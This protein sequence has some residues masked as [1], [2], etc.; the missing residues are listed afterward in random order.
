MPAAVLALGLTALP[1]AARDGLD[2][3]D[4]RVAAAPTDLDAYY[5][6]HLV[7][8]RET[9]YR[10]AERRL[11][12]L[13][14]RDP[15]NDW[16]RLVLASIRGDQNGADA[17]EL[18]TAAADGFAARG[19]GKGEILA[20]IFLA[21]YHQLRGRAPLAD[22]PLSRA[23]ELADAA[24]DPI[25]S[26][27]VR[28]AEAWQSYRKGDHGRALRLLDGVQD[29]VFGQGP[30]QLQST[31]L[32]ASAI[33][34]WALG[35]HTEAME[36]YR[37][38]AELLR[39]QGDRYEEAVAR[40]NIIF[41]APILGMSREERLPLAQELLA[42]AIAGGNRSMEARAH[43]YLAGLTSGREAITHGR[44]YLLMSRQTKRAS[45]IVMALRSLAPLLAEEDPQEARRLVDEAAA[46]ARESGDL[47]EVARVQVARSTVSWMTGLRSQA[48]AESLAALDAIEAT[49]GR[50]PE[51][52]VRARRFSQ[53]RSVYTRLTGSL[54]SGRLLAAGDV[55][56]AEDV[57]LA[58]HV[59]ERRRAR[60]LLDEMDAARATGAPGLVALSP[61]R[62]ATLAE[63][64]SALEDDEALLSFQIAEHGAS[65]SPIGEGAGGCWLIVQTRHRTRLYPL[66][67]EA[68][69]A[70][71]LFVGLFERRDGS[72]AVPASRL[73]AHLLE[74]ALGDLP[75]IRRLVVVPDDVLHRVPFDAL[76]VG[77]VEPLGAR[78][79]IS[80]VPSATLWLRL[81]RLRATL[82][83]APA[84]ALSDPDLGVASESATERQW[85]LDVGA[86]LGRLPHARREGGMIVRRL[87][88]GSRVLS[89]L[90]AS[91]EYLKQADLSRYALL[92]FAAHAVVDESKPERSA[93]LLAPGS[94]TEDGLLQVRELVGLDLG[95]RVVVLSTCRSASGALI[96]GEGLLSLAHGFFQAGARTVVGTLWPL[97]DDEAER[98]FDAF[99]G[100]LAQGLSVG[101]ALAGARRERIDA[102]APAAAWAGMVLLGDATAVPVPGGRPSGGSRGW[103]AA[104]IAV[105]GAVVGALLVRSRSRRAPGP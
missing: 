47:E 18:Y 72:E 33:V 37:R 21:T 99:Y 94:A 70:V 40:G 59:T 11:R 16:A 104:S 32:S 26:A 9:R 97:R 86:R 102:G 38:Q 100:R 12:A 63:L 49:R 46:L 42:A 29:V 1:A 3:C 17:E 27:R 67:A 88:G 20:R 79:D 34:C 78:Y 103:A 84:L 95:R 10:E 105:V 13:L 51:A 65:S 57:E 24:A 64:K 2:A 4:A 98:L 14:H 58:F 69:T 96:G 19:D 66:P 5:C 43:D 39:D 87:G 73:G 7:A 89:G 48:I 82:A 76:R 15:R 45:A 91:E 31:W 56:S 83:E 28:V 36:H 90:E 60:M 75:A 101:E 54:L 68:M 8:R 50:Q 92:H 35:R 80:V 61:P 71:P 23:R 77:E 53:W 93:I 52:L 6:Y 25:L 41:M 22:A 74:R 62:L 81:R 30:L 55:P 44:Q 85:A